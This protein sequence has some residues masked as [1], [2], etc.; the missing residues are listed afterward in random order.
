MTRI[1]AV[2]A[3]A[4]VLAGGG[5]A[6]YASA[7]PPAGTD[8]WTVDA[9]GS[10]LRRLTNDPDPDFQPAASPSGRLIAWARGS[11]S[12]IWRMRADG[13]QR[14]QLTSTPEDAFDPQWS[15]D[16][17]QL[18]YMT[19]DS[20]S[21]QPGSKWC[22]VTDV[23]V[24]N[25]DGS[26]PR[27]L[28][29]GIHPR[30]APDS[31]RLVYYDFV[32]NIQSSGL[33]LAV[34]TQ[35]GGGDSSFLS[36][37]FV[38]PMASPPAWSP[39]GGWIAFAHALATR[40]RRVDVVRPAGTPRRRIGLGTAPAWAPNGRTLAVVRSGWI[41]LSDPVGGHRRRLVRTLPGSN[42]V[43]AWSPHGKLLAF[44]GPAGLMVARATPPSR[45]RLVAP[46]LMDC[47]RHEFGPST[48]AWTRDGRRLIFSVSR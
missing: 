45:P 9:N 18:V 36:A 34:V 10:H 7:D 19:W 41:W 1:A 47:C 22:A 38:A 40:G 25:A 5:A 2:L 48:A 43:P 3:V 12:Q 16:G 33:T 42:L 11:P 32:P 37:G 39:R 24:I 6:P 35:S 31:R 28:G 30:W 26:N 15:P 20:S 23:W 17:R 46:G 27:L 13:T 4:A 21:C 29:T 44:Q 8:V 14:R